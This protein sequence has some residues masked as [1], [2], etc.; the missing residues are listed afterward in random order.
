MYKELVI[1]IMVIALIVI[2]NIVTQDNT[3]KSVNQISNQLN[4]L[5][6]EVSKEFVNQ[7]DVKKK[8]KEIQKIWEE[9]Y[10]AMAYYIEH[11]ELEK[12]ETE[13][14]KLKADIDMKEYSMG[15]ENLDNCSFILEHIKDKTALK[16]VNIF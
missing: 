8:M 1:S 15:V 2:G 6:E 10:E 14:T 4:I 11:N 13:L 16:I 7:E 12:V 9:K 5:R 3:V